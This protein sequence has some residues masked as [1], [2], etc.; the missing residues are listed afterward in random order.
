[1]M[2]AKATYLRELER[3]AV[4]AERVSFLE[5]YPYPGD[6]ALAL[7]PGTTRQTPALEAIDRELRMVATGEN[8]RLMLFVPPQEGKS[9]RTACWYPLWRLAADPSIR[10]GIVSYSQGKAARWGKWIRRMIESH[11]ELGI[12]LVQGSRAAD[13]F[14]TTAGG[15][16]ISVGIEGGITG[17][18]VDELIIDD[19][20]RGRAEAESP[21]YR[22]AA[23]EWWESNAM[24]RASSRFRVILMMTRW[25]ADDLAGRLT[26]L[27]PGDW[28]T[29]RIPALR[30]DAAEIARGHDGRSVYNGDGELISV[31]DRARGWFRKLKSLRSQ[32]VWLSIYAQA[33][34]AAEG[35]LFVK[36]DFVYW[37][38]LRAHAEMH[39]GL[40]GQRIAMLGEQRYLA[41]MTRFIT[42]DLAASVKTSSDWTVAAAWGI[43]GDGYL[44]LLDL[45][46]QRVQEGDHFGLV[47]PIA[48]RFGIRDIYVERGFIGTT[49]VIDATRSG[50]AVKPLSPDK[51]K[52]T[53]ALPAVDR[54]RQHKIVLPAGADWLGDYLA[55]LAEFPQGTHDDMADV[56]AYAA[57]VAAAEWMP[58]HVTPAPRTQF[59]RPADTQ[60]AYES[61][62]GRAYQAPEIDL[63]RAQW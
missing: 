6:F 45:A 27:E 21:T 12:E 24:T 4:E 35:N 10:I 22:D 52:V 42:M 57:R 51:D 41:D 53:R 60:V 18:S 7:A 25:H 38:W 28:R 54:S 17:E 48:T 58:P 55:E 62:T 56:T 15:K 30:E 13:H 59:T 14:E 8:D 47:R 46:R 29:L 36:A 31:Q 32:Y 9:T 63:N 43:T 11:P 61:A 5:R 37:Q 23:W 40:S 2:L 26:K 33:P 34:T 1:M 39:D 49:L 50:Y 20:V 3:L 19:P 16:V 44:V